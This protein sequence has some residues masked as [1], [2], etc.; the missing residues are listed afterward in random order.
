M[1]L[2]STWLQLKTLVE[3]LLVIV[4]NCSH[5]YYTVWILNLNIA[6]IHSHIAQFCLFLGSIDSLRAQVNVSMKNKICCRKSCCRLSVLFISF[7]WKVAKSTWEK[8]LNGVERV[9][10]VY[11]KYW[12]MSY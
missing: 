6:C 4:S 10:L 1:R 11:R 7:K 5:I 8:V 2:P 9:K 12:V 3:G